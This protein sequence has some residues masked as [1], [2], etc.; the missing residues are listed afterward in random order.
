MLNAFILSSLSFASFFFRDTANSYCSLRPK[1]PAKIHRKYVDRQNDFSIS[2]L[3][4]DVFVEYLF[5][6]EPESPRNY[7]SKY[8]L[9]RHFLL[10][11]FL[12]EIQKFI[13]MFF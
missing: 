13:C 1:P 10:W 2:R 9:L 3:R 6:Y 4:N 8:L 5:E 11:I 7:C 12:S